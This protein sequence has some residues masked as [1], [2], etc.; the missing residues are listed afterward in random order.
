MP[1]I[2]RIHSGAIGT[3]DYWVDC[4]VIKIGSHPNC[5]VVLSS[6]S[7][8]P[9]AF[10]IEFRNAQY[11][12]LNKTQAALQVGGRDVPPNSKDVWRH[13]EHLDVGGVAKLELHLDKKDPSPKPKPILA[14]SIPIPVEVAKPSSDEPP[15]ENAKTTSSGLSTKER[16]QMGVTAICCLGCIG[17]VVLKFLPQEKTTQDNAPRVTSA[18][19]FADSKSVAETDTSYHKLI[20]ELKAARVLRASGNFQEAL[21]HVTHI[22]DVLHSRRDVQGQFSKGEEHYERLYQYVAGQ[23]TSLQPKIAEE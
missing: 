15:S 20:E 19:I 5:D 13:G 22:R 3:N 4:P 11:F 6:P 16:I 18:Q 8:L 12:V 17:L 2:I 9:H 23:V 21:R 10:T 1:A 7:I 14:P